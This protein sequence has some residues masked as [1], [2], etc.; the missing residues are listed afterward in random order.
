MAGFLCTTV[1]H[2]ALLFQAEPVS[3]ML[4]TTESCLSPIWIKRCAMNC[5]RPGGTPPQRNLGAAEV[6][7]QR[8][9][10]RGSRLR[11]QSPIGS[12]GRR[13]GTTTQAMTAGLHSD[14]LAC[15][16]SPL[17]ADLPS[18]NSNVTSLYIE[19]LSLLQHVVTRPCQFVR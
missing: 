19:G 12:P 1:L 14:H 13:P 11:V 4:A 17:L 18:P 7:G 2:P 6:S 3:S 15:I 8:S 5:L 9:Q 16:Q 10:I